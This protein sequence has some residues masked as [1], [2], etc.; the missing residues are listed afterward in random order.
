MGCYKPYIIGSRITS[1]KWPPIQYLKVV[2]HTRDFLR[3]KNLLLKLLLSTLTIYLHWETKQ[4]LYI[5]SSTSINNMHQG[6]WICLSIFFMFDCSWSQVH[7]HIYIYQPDM[8]SN[9]KNS[10]KIMWVILWS[11][12]LFLHC[13]RGLYKVRGNKL[14]LR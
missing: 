3:I 2:S 10:F 1:T 13:T 11:L 4:N 12:V 8:I 9:I 5:P 6:L 14:L 7:N